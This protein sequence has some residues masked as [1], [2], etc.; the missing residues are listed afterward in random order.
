[1]IP[2]IIMQE[3]LLIFFLIVFFGLLF[4]EGLNSILENFEIFFDFLF[5]ILFLVFVFPID[6]I[7]LIEVLS[8]SL[9][10]Y[11]DIVVN[12]LLCEN[13]FGGRI[14]DIFLLVSA[15]KV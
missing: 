6:F 10:C 1:M 3:L 9:S 5:E 7:Y 2:F 12:V 14:R 11:H 8:S 4:F 15:C 13:I